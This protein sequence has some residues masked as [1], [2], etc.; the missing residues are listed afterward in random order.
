MKRTAIVFL[1]VLL[2]LAIYAAPVVS[3]LK[4]KPATRTKITAPEEPV[5]APA[6]PPKVDPPA[7]LDVSF[8][9]NKE[10]ISLPFLGHD[11]E[12]LFNTFDARKKAERKDEFETTEQY[13][14]RLR[15]QAVQPLFG[16]IAPDAILAFVMNPGANYD[17]D[18]QTLTLSIITS[19]VWESVQIDKTRLALSIKQAKPTKEKTM[20]QNAYGAQVEI[21]KTYAK[22]FELAIHNYSSFQ[23]ENTLPE[24]MRRIMERPDMPKPDAKFVESLKKPS[25]V[26][27]INM[28]PEEARVA[29]DRITALILAR[30][31]TP[32]I[33]Y[34][35]VL[36]KATFKD[37]T[38]FFSQMYYLDVDL[39]EIWLYDKTTGEIVSKAK[40]R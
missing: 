37:P 40:S 25:F 8:D 7:C 2:Q 18:S 30:P 36:R 6:A 35:A 16:S 33:S 3:A 38:E 19:A 23:M 14:A 12:Q 27:K 39:L 32:Y 20:G 29:K 11:V 17:A 26:Q 21:E 34:G 9:I 28:Q 10:K 4:Q 13:Q 1:I 15:K 31:T 5:A 22:A 24:N